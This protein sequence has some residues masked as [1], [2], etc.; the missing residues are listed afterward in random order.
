MSLS[1]YGATLGRQTL[2]GGTLTTRQE[3][4]RLI[5]I[6]P[7]TTAASTFP[8]MRG[9]HGASS[10]FPFRQFHRSPTMADDRNNQDRD[11][12]AP[13]AGGDTEDALRQE[14]EREGKEAK[15]G[16]GDVAQDRNLSGSSSWLTEPKDSASGSGDAGKGEGRSR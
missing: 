3:M 2:L 1:S 4:V 8:L 14:L 9:T 15:G 16:I 5:V 7:F 6:V 10:S 12:K 13:A 11:T